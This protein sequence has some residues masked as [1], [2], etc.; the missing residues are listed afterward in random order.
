M[1][2]R[3]EGEVPATIEKVMMNHILFTMALSDDADHFPIVM[4]YTKE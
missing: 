2:L 1:A 3:I 4:H